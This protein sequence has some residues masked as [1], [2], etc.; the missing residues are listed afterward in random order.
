MLLQSFL[1]EY[2]VA[3]GKDALENYKP[4]D[5]K[6]EKKHKLN[7]LLRDVTSASLGNQMLNIKK[8]ICKC[9]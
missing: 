7:E 4:K 8:T 2:Y 9:I 1:W 6:T 3:N 5:A